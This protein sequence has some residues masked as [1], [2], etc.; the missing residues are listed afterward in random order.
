V[1]VRPDDIVFG[2]RYR[3]GWRILPG[4]DPRRAVRA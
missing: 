4:E 1:P 2:V 3:S